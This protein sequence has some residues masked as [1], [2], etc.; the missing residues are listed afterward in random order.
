MTNINGRFKSR[1][2]G[3]TTGMKYFT[4]RFVRPNDLNM[5]N[6]LF[7]GQL[8]SWIDEEAAIY[9]SCQ[10]NHD[11]VV[12]KYMSEIDFKLSAQTGDILEFGLEVVQTGRTSLSV[13]C[14]VRHKKSKAVV[15]KVER[16]VFVAIGETGAPVPYKQTPLPV[17]LNM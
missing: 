17:V 12:T 8:L 9:A 10:M 2:S 7:G 11:R 1:S 15:I 3:Q 13:R 6:R 5:S 16:I 14:E 4:R